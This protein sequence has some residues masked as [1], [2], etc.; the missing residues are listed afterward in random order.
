[1]KSKFTTTKKIVGIALHNAKAG[2]SAMIQIGC[3]AKTNKAKNNVKKGI[4]KVLI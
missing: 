1:M 3:T 4:Q 2:D